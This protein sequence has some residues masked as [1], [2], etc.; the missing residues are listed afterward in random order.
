MIDTMPNLRRSVLLLLAIAAAAAEKRPMTPLD[1]IK[2]RKLDSYGASPDGRWVLYAQNV[3]NWEKGANYTDLFLAAADGSSHRQMTFTKEAG[4]KPFAWARDSGWFAF[5]S[6]REAGKKQVF[7]MTT[8]GGEARRLTS[9]KDRVNSFALSR[10]GHWL[11][12]KGGPEDNRQLKLIDLRDAEYKS[13]DLP[14][15]ATPVEQWAWH[16]DSKRI[17]FTAGEQDESVHARRKKLGFDVKVNALEQSPRNLWVLDVAGD[18][19]ARITSLSDFS[20]TSLRFSRDGRFLA[21]Y[22]NCHAPLCDTLEC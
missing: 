15:H 22:R 8:A 6:E 13:K 11:V 2:L 20:A 3:P 18:K 4:E 17:Y 5:L 21:F 14:K 1:I 12:Y 9:E 16:P 10:D 7:L 19:A